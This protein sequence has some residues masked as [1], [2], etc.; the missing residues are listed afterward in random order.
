MPRALQ[1]REQSRMRGWASCRM[2][3]VD[4]HNHLLGAVSEEA[5][6]NAA[7]ARIFRWLSPVAHAF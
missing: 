1:D 6:A 5:W 4:Q 2:T 7:A 3:H